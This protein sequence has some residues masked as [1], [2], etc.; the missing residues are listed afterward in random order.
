MTLLK[1]K[2]ADKISQWRDEALDLVK[3]SGDK[4]ISDVTVAQAYGGMR[5]VRG[6]VCDTS[7]VSA[8][9]GL[10]IRGHPLLDI[11]HLSDKEVDA[12]DDAAFSR[13]CSASARDL[14]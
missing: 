9:K 13:P 11:T 12:V 3:N 14:E 5:G 8:E 7:S 10:I 6:F 1:Q 2:L 4:K